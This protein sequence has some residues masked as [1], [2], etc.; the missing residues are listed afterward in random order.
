MLFPK[1]SV[2]TLPG[3]LRF[4]SGFL[5]RLLP[6]EALGL[7]PHTDVGHNGD[8]GEEDKRLDDTDIIADVRCIFDFQDQA[9]EF[10]D[11]IN[12]SAAA[13]EF[14][15]YR[16]FNTSVAKEAGLEGAQVQSRVTLGDAAEPVGS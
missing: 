8:N 12:E 5:H 2:S 16:I 4:R 14:S 6:T 3:R 1:R 7:S 13:E 15:M 10:A 11:A 9:K